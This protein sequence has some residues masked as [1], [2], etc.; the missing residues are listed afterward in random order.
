MESVK[1]ELYDLFENK[2]DATRATPI[3]VI[4]SQPGDKDIGKIPQR[5]PKILHSSTQ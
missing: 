2:V 1:Q 3:D 5:S 4:Y